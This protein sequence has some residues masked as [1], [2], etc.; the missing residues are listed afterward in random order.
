MRTCGSGQ[1]WTLVLAEGGEWIEP[2]VGAK[3]EREKQTRRKNSLIGKL[4][5]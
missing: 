3:M 4:L 1:R 5:G 2:E